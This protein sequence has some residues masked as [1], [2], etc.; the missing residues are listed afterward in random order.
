MQEPGE[1]GYI[2]LTRNRYGKDAKANAVEFSTNAANRNGWS[3]YG[4]M[5]YIPHMLLYYSLGR[6]FYAPDT[7]ELIV[8]VATSPIGNV[9]S[10]SYW[11]WY[12]FAERVEN[13]RVYTIKGNTSDGCRQRSYPVA[14][15]QIPRLRYPRLL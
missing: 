5:N 13:R 6:S 4:D 1:L 15:Y 9:G 10:E 2:T 7:S 8:E 14:C 3:S 11:S 12:G